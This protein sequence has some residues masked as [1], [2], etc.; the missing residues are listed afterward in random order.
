MS[1]ADN[2]NTSW[3]DSDLQRYLKGELSPREMHALEK[4]ALDDP[5][6]SDA[7]EGLA[8]PHPE[9]DLSELKARLSKLEAAKGKAP[10]PAKAKPAAH[11]TKRKRRA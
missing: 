2:H 8:T 11:K 3:S 4:A 6:L 1:S 5:F 7:L 10:P 9:T